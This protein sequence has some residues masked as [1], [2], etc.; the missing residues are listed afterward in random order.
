MYR[1]RYMRF[2]FDGCGGHIA[3][4]PWPAAFGAVPS[5]AACAAPFAAVVA[6]GV[7]AVDIFLCASVLLSGACRR[8]SPEHPDKIFRLTQR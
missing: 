2:A 1:M 8:R 5:I 6:G 3:W 4:P 7:L